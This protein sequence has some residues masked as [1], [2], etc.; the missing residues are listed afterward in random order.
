[1]SKGEVDYDNIKLVAEQIMALLTQLC[2][3]DG[4]YV[5][6]KEKMRIMASILG[7]KKG[8]A[9]AQTSNNVILWDGP[10]GLVTTTVH[11]ITNEPHEPD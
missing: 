5:V 11:V 2:P 1:M 3:Y 8:M 10:Q 9:L 4:A 7:D 6:S